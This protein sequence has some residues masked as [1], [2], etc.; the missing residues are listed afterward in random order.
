MTPERQIL[1]PGFTGQWNLA[2]LPAMALPVGHTAGAPK[3]PLSMQLIGKA[4]DEATVF[5]VGDAYQR[6]T[7]FHLQI[8]THA[9]S[10]VAV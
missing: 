4:F 2:G 8:P 3:L 9:L 1:Q 6:V 7:D 5:Q 10:A